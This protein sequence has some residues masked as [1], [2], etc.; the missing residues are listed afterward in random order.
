M[1]KTICSLLIASGV[2]VSFGANAQEALT[3]AGAT[4]V[5]PETSTTATA[6]CDLLGETVTIN[7]SRAVHGA[8]MCDEATNAVT[9]A[10]CHETGSR[11]PATVQCVTLGE[12]TDAINVPEG[13]TP[14]TEVELEVAYRGFVANSR[15]GGVATTALGGNCTDTTVTAII[16]TP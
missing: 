1:K 11:K 8:F 14:G 15:G 3:T 13:C 4:L 5:G 7:L 16:P 10:T 9:I 6:T 2:F 12:G